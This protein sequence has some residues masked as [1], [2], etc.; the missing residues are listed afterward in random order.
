M[1]FFRLEVVAL[2][3][4][5]AALAQNDR[6]TITGTVADPT[7]ALVPSAA[8][9]ARNVET[10]AVYEAATTATGNYALAQLPA[11]VYEMT[12]AA[13]GFGKYVRQGIT[14][15]V[16]QTERID[17]VLQ[18]ASAGESVTVTADAPLLRTDS[19]EMSQNLS[20]SRVGEL[21]LYG[22]R[23]AEAGLQNPYAFVRVMPGATLLPG[24]GQNNSIR[25][26]GMPNDTFNVQIEGQESTFT[27]FRTYEAAIQPGV[28]A[29]QEVA[30]Q[31][32][33][34]SAEFG[35]VGGG[36]INFTAKSGT[37]ELH[38]SAYGFLK[39]EFLNAGQPF[40]NNGNGHLVRPMARGD[41]LGGSVGGPVYIPHV[42]HG[43][44]KTFFFVNFEYANSPTWAAGLVETVPATALRNGDFSGILTG[45][46]LA[47]DPR[48]RPIMENTIYDPL[49][50]RV[51]NGQVVTDPFYGNIIPPSRISPIA[52]KIQAMFPLPTL[53]GLRNNYTPTAT[54]VATP[55][56]SVGPNPGEDSQ[57]DTVTTFKI[58]HS[59]SDKSKLSFYYSRRGNIIERQM[60]SIPVPLAS[61]RENRLWSPT[62]RLNY[63]QTISPT[64]L[65]HVGAG[66][67]R[68]KQ[69]DKAIPGELEYDAPSKLGLIGGIETNFYG[70]L[71]TPSA[72]FPR[73]N[74]LDTA[75]G[76]FDSILST[77]LSPSTIGPVNAD[78]YYVEKPSLV[79]SATLVRS[80]H[81]F[82]AGVDWRKNAL[83]DRN[84]RGSQGIW[85]FSNLETALPSTN[86]Q[87]LGGGAVGFS[88]AS[89]LLGLADSASVTTPNDAQSRRAS[90]AMYVQD[91]W[92]VTRRLTLEYGLRW[93]YQAPFT[94]LH[95]R[96]SAFSPTIAN[97]SAGGLRGAIAYAGSGAGRIGGEF[98]K[99]YPYAIGPRLGFAYQIAPKTVL[100]G[101]WG[102]TYS[103]PSG[104]TAATNPTI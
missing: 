95:D 64:F 62:I 91:S 84:V 87:A 49:T 99:N 7:G 52:A 22:A 23:G 31:T 57:G 14:V 15:Q 16:A 102:L 88:Y 79:L 10:G 55:G 92:K 29:L 17:V 4:T 69:Q 6:G 48:G 51:V 65:L 97:P 39:N 27:M 76:G 32:S 67:I 89:F 24:S 78:Y 72:G 3:F 82:K 61:G 9:T 8:I 45:R 38:G 26:N 93:D 46:Q 2:L 43:K 54:P 21:P 70:N 35:Q 100:R 50:S 5:V 41:T 28:E 47:T 73:I 86:G 11:A 103:E 81:S 60:D 33:N 66:F 1:R 96:V 30:L 53:S 63:D 34:Y 37:N 101:G 90:W 25:V 80:N 58:D 18:L 77:N 59:I 71:S 75:F 104:G 56:T 36:F 85:T 98:T 13:A 94:E 74:G 68:S 42:Y 83:T 19:T 12:V 40:S 44:N 20:T